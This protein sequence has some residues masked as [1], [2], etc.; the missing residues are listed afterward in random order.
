M[1]TRFMIFIAVVLASGCGAATEDQPPTTPEPSEEAASA[2]ATPAEPAVTPS[3]DP[4]TPVRILAEALE[5]QDFDAM[6]EAIHP[7]LRE[8]AGQELRSE[9]DLSPLATCVRATLDLAHAEPLESERESL[10]ELGE[11]P[12]QLSTPS[13]DDEA[14]VILH[15]G[16]YY[17]L[18]TGC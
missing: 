14:I 1:L 9:P 16:R 12:M 7:S 8:A 15:E 13:E 2:D 11:A 3:P 10:A 5:Q 4:F 17:L 18:D 6:L